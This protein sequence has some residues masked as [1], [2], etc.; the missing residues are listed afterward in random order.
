M[1][2]HRTPEQW[3][4]LVDQHRD[5]GLSA[6]QFCKQENIGYSSFCNWRKRL[7]DQ[8]TDNS[9]DSG[10]ASFLDLS[11]L[12]GTSPSSGLGWNIVL[13]LG[14]GVELRLSQNG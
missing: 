3:Q 8:P 6:S 1:R 5:S 14:N 7:S 4:A 10:E 11:S 2:K 12:M 13:S 9:T